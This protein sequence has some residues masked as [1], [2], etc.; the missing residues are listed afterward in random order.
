MRAMFAAVLLS[1]GSVVASSSERHEFS[2]RAMGTSTRIVVFASTEEAARHAA[3]A[4]F[5]RIDALDGVMSDYR[6]GSELSAL[7]RRAGKGPMRVSEDLFR[8]LDASQRI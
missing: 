3:S 1:C 4:A 5:A 2:S 6:D 8:V 7:C